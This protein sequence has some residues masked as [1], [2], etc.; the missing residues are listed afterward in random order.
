VTELVSQLTAEVHLLSAVGVSSWQLKAGRFQEP[1]GRRTSD[2][3][4]RYRTTANEDVIVCPSVCA[5]VRA[6]VYI[7]VNCKV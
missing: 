4:N 7:I 1:R 2:F 6:C 3:G 5:R